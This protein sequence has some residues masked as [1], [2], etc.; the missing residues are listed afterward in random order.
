MVAPQQNGEGE[1]TAKRDDQGGL[2]I[3]DQADL[4]L[5]MP[6]HVGDHEPKGGSHQERIWPEAHNGVT[7]AQHHF[8]RQNGQ[9]VDG[10]EDQD[11][12]LILTALLPL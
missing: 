6:H 9:Q 7:A 8:R 12:L 3:G 11:L 1:R 2:A 10:V 4:A 5:A